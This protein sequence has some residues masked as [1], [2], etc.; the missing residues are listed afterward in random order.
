MRK[1]YDIGALIIGLFIGLA[2]SGQPVYATSAENQTA[3]A[4]STAD[5]VETV[6]IGE[7]SYSIVE[8]FSA[9]N[10]P[11]DFVE[12]TVTYHEKEY[13]GVQ[14]SKGTIQMLYLVS[15]DPTADSKGVF[16][17]YDATGDTWYPFV[18][19]SH[20]DSYVIAVPVT[21]DAVLDETY[22]ETSFSTAD[23]TS[24]AA[25]QQ[26]SDE[27]SDFYLFYGM[28]QDGTAG[29]YQ[30]DAAEGTYQR[31]Q[32]AASE[33]DSSNAD[34][35]Y[36]QEEYNNLSAQY[37]QEKSFSRNAIAVM[38]FISAVL[39]III[40][41]LLVRRSE[42]KWDG[43]AIRHRRGRDDLDDDDSFEEDDDLD[44]KDSFEEDDDFDEKDSFEE[45]D[46]FDE[47][48]SD[49]EGHDGEEELWED[50]FV[51]EKPDIKEDELP[52][53]PVKHE[54]LPGG[55]E[56]DEARERHR[57]MESF[58]SEDDEAADAGRGHERRE[59]KPEKVKLPKKEKQPR[60]E[61]PVKIKK[62]ENPEKI[63]KEKTEKTAHGDDDL[64]IIDFNDL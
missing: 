46:D 60:K 4:E 37:K 36:L 51:E 10:I 39:L 40:V 43:E 53:E 21:S 14:F 47:K 61:K 24:V 58:F 62:S 52:E 33:E 20:G 7:A 34:M 12:A 55:L 35:E 38:V 63:D 45:D 48:K 9:D 11:Q 57:A 54:P 19:M 28:N 49:V 50:D 64:E 25:Y 44:E 1:K 15:A 41:N 59:K 22:Q 2:L 3:E 18:K 56:D 17:I 13:S 42:R 23:G 29:W 30:Y 6:T 31:Y 8:N 27:A 32:A 5:T 16:F 26:T